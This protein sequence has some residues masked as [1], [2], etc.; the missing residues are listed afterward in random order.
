MA[1]MVWYWAGPDFLVDAATDYGMLWGW[2]ALDFAGGL[3]T[4]NY[5]VAD[6]GWT[7]LHALQEVRRHSADAEVFTYLFVLSPEGSLLGVVSLKQIFQAPPRVT[8]GKLMATK[9]V[10]FF[11]WTRREDVERIFAKYGFRSVP[12]VDE[13][14][15]MQGVVRF[16]RILELLGRRP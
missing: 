12:V 16:R 10:T 1:H 4:T 9:L 6:P 11:P 15:R 8:I 13:D 7:A 5:L 14:G 2:G 3:M